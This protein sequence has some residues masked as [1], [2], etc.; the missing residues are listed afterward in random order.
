MKL[1]YQGGSIA[2]HIN[3]YNL[4][5]RLIKIYLYSNMK[6]E[7]KIKSFSLKQDCNF[8]KTDICLNDAIINKVTKSK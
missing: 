4:I 2:C 7:N 3:K 1:E 5:E 8:I 6:P